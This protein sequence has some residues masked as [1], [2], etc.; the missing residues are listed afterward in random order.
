MT[1]A[2]RMVGFDADDTLWKSEDY[3]RAAEAEFR[4]IVAGYIDLGDLGGRLYEVEKRNLAVFGYGAKGMVLSMVEA[5]IEVTDARI[6]AADIHR[7]VS[8]GRGLLLHPV[9][10][11]PGISA[12]V[13]AMAARFPVVLITK[14]DLFHQEAKVRASGLAD[15]FQRIEIVSEKDPETYARLFHEFGVRPEE[16]VMVGNSL[17]SDIAPVLELGGAGIH[18]PYHVTWAHEAEHDVDAAHP[19]L[20]QVDDASGIFAAVA[21]LAFGNG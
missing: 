10:L 18:I 11:L 6:V 16:F 9:E 20:R 5:A 17:R 15:R 21:D 1:T 19:R 7:I 8:L 12:A 4:R 3:Y 2:I 13:D 14:G